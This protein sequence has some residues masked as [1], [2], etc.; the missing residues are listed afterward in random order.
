MTL[1]II[2]PNVVFN[3]PAAESIRRIESQRGKLFFNR[4]TVPYNEQE[5]LYEEWLRGEH[6]EI[7]V[8]LNPKYSTHCYREDDDHSA[9]ASDSDIRGDFWEDNGWI[10]TN[11]KELWHREYRVEKDNH[12]NDVI[13]PEGFDMSTIEIITCPA[14]EAANQRVVTNGSACMIVPAGWTIENIQKGIAFRAYDT[15][16]AM[17]NEVAFAWQLGGLSV[18]EVQRNIDKIANAVKDM[19]G[20]TIKEVPVL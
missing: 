8:V 15:N 19:P 5:K 10:L 14:Y 3:K 7:P 18:A 20:T 9:S 16:N 11:Y 13:I 2:R 17:L 6:P 1:E 4:T 12:I